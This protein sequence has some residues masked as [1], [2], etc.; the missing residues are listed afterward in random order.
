MPRVR[1]RHSSMRT[2]HWA[3]APGSW[4]WRELPGLAIRSAKPE[5]LDV[6]ARRVV[7][8]RRRRGRL[9]EAGRADQLITQAEDASTLDRVRRVVDLAAPQ[10]ASAPD[11]QVVALDQEV[12][13]CAGR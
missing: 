13:Q 12:L 9:R 8:Q 3:W 6:H 2:R 11:V 1:S 7:H 10:L 5:D 4:S